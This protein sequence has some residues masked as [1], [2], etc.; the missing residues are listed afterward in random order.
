VFEREREPRLISDRFH[1]SHFFD[2]L[3]VDGMQGQE[4]GWGDP[5][6]GVQTNLQDESGKG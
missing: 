4:I 2:F 3:I 6:E 1:D 5:F